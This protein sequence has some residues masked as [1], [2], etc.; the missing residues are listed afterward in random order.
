MSTILL[1]QCPL[2]KVKS[3]NGRTVKGY[4]RVQTFKAVERD[5]KCLDDI[6]ADLDKLQRRTNAAVIRGGLTQ[7]GRQQAHVLRRA[8][9]DP[10]H[11]QPVERDWIA[12]DIDGA[13]APAE[14]RFGNA[15]EHAQRAL[16][17]AQWL[18]NQYLPAQ[19]SFNGLRVKGSTA[20]RCM[21]A[22]G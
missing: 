1:A 13:P 2:T 15:Q 18:V 4:P 22:S 7:L 14:L 19:L 3:A 10:K 11:F 21:R 16:D 17:R 12:L 8:Y 9:Q 5:W 6:A 20:R